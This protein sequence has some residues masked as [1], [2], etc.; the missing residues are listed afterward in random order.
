MELFEI[1]KIVLL[2]CFLLGGNEIE[3]FDI[4]IR[5]DEINLILHAH[6]FDKHIC[7]MHI[8]QIHHILNAFLHDNLLGLASRFEQRQLDVVV[9][10]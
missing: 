2:L 9:P 3:F 5:F 6:A 10:C 8:L 7:K 1:P 4:K